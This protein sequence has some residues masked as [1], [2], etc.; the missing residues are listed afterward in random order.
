MAAKFS[1]CTNFFCRHLNPG[2]GSG[3]GPECCCVVWCPPSSPVPPP[4]LRPS[5][6]CAVCLCVLQVRAASTVTSW[7]NQ[8]PTALPTV[9]PPLQDQQVHRPPTWP[10]HT[11]VL[12]FTDVLAR[13]L[14]PQWF[15]ITNYDSLKI[16]SGCFGASVVTCLHPQRLPVSPVMRSL[17]LSP[18]LVSPAPPVIGLIRH[19][20]HVCLLVTL[21]MLLL[22]RLI[23]SRCI[24]VFLIIFFRLIRIRFDTRLFCPVQHQALFLQWEEKVF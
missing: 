22:V 24:N 10:P 6:V 13:R 20:P 2:S 14:P 19:H 5:L 8:T 7:S 1:Q 11:P 15:Q 12:M 23:W 3:S 18:S 21:C 4:M 17:S 16:L 9:P